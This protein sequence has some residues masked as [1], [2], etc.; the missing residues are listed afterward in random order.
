MTLSQPLQPFEQC[1]PKASLYPVTLPFSEAVES[2]KVT[3]ADISVDKQ[4]IFPKLS[5]IN[6]QLDRFLLVYLP[7]HFNGNEFIHSQTQSC[8]HKN[9]LKLG[10]NL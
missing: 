9:F 8:I 5:E 3:V 1:L 2:I 10:R 4:A 6:V 7:F